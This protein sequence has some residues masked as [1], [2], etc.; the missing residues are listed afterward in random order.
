MKKLIWIGLL[1]GFVA[2]EKSE[3]EIPA[4]LEEKIDDILS[5]EVWNPPAKLYS[6]QY[7]GETVFYFP[8]RCCDFFG[9]VFDAECNYICAPDGGI[10][11]SGDG[12][13]PDFF[14]KAT[15]ETLLWEDPRSNCDAEIVVSENKFNNAVEQYG[16]IIS[17]EINGDCLTIEYGASGCDGSTW[18]TALYD[19]GVVMESF[20]VQRNIRFSVI[21]N[22][23]C[24]AYFTK[25]VSFDLRTI[26]VTSEGEV[27]LNLDNFADQLSYVY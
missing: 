25:Q 13:C 1:I 17:A 16:S 4:C 12:D 22:E 8:P 15:N 23:D 21:N 5:E 27:R 11:G 9:E 20:P 7:E 24:D 14:Q 6:Y 2:C 19:A 3:P 10:T 18:E 26:Q